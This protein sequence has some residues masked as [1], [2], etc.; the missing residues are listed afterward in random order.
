[1]IK[2]KDRAGR[3]L[4]KIK[5]RS[6]K[7]AEAAGEIICPCCTA[8][9]GQREKSWEMNAFAKRQKTGCHSADEVEQYLIRE[10]RARR[11]SGDSK[12]CRQMRVRMRMELIDAYS[13][14]LLP[15]PARYPE[16]KNDAE[17]LRR[18]FDYMARREDRAEEISEEEFPTDFVFYEIGIRV[19]ENPSMAACLAASIRKR[20]AGGSGEPEGRRTG[21]VIRIAIEKNRE[22]IRAEAAGERPALDAAGKMLWEIYSFYGVSKRDIKEQNARFLNLFYLSRRYGRAGGEAAQAKGRIK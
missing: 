11:L 18:Y 3:L 9:N 1:M 4:I 7:K 19:S 2:W 8:G 20:I 14:W 6:A 17:K 21:A 12:R 13:P 5:E 22:R 10:C 16:A 15:R